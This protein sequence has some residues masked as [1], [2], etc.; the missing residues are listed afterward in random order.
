[1]VVKYFENPVQVKFYNET[2]GRFLGGIGYKDS[3]ICGEC[4][5]VVSLSEIYDNCKNI[6]DPVKILEWIDISESI[7]GE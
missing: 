7:I 6:K 4:G 2:D 3:I 5:C 1:M